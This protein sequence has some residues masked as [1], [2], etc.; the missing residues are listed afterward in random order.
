MRILLIN[1]KRVGRQ[2]FTRYM[3]STPLALSTLKALTPQDIEVRIIDENNEPVEFN[4]HWDLVGITVM[5]H[6]SPTA[7]QIAAKFHQR[8]IKVVF[9]GFFSTLSYEFARP[10]ADVIVSGEAEYV[11]P[12][13]ISDLRKGALKPFY[14]SERLIDLKDIP[15]IRKEYYSPYDFTYHTETTRGCPYNCDFCSVTSF[16]GAKFRHRPIDHVVRQLDELRD[17][18]IFFVDDN[19]TGNPKY[20][21][22]LFKAIAPL[23]IK[24]SSQFSLSNAQDH[25]IMRLAAESG[26]QLLFTGIESLNLKNLQEVGKTWAKPEKYKQWIKSTHDAGI[27]IYGSFMFGFDNDEPDIFKRTWDFCQ[28]NE[29][30]L[31]QFSVL[32]P[33]K[34][35]FYEKLIKEN[36]IFEIDHAKFNGLYPTFYPKNM[37]VEQL[38]DGLVWIWKTFYSKENIKSR[39]AR[40]I[41]KEKSSDSKNKPGYSPIDQT[42]AGTLMALN[43]SFNIAV[44][45]L[46]C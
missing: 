46:K 45:D 25:E 33:I 18:P 15:F 5:F 24:W 36:R 10:Y 14:K 35:K 1:P 7:I 19:I 4:E 17:K 40:L 44:Q 16:Y 29:I 13:V 38:N 11:W 28:E 22:E 20:A 2:A 3:S 27:G 12:D 6:N 43:I 39:L 21:R 32:S 42:L 23:K 37:T 8:G 26:C 30:E 9:G 41:G 31:A 34:G